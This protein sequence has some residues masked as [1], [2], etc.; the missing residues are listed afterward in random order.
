MVTEAQWFSA[1]L[2]TQRQV[3]CY[4]HTVS[5]ANKMP[6]LSNSKS[7]K[8][9][10]SIYSESSR[11]RWVERPQLQRGYSISFPRRTSHT[12]NQEF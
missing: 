5:C 1:S 11:Q 12:A 10:A 4:T 7:P 3:F 6:A 9:I 2:P 8:G